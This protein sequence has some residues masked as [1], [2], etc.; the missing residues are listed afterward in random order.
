LFGALETDAWKDSGTCDGSILTNENC[1]REARVNYVLQLMPL[2]RRKKLAGLRESLRSEVAFA[3]KL[4]AGINY[5][6]NLVRTFQ[7]LNDNALPGALINSNFFNSGSDAGK[8]E[9]L[10]VESARSI[11]LQVFR[12]NGGRVMTSDSILIDVEPEECNQSCMFVYFKELLYSPG[13]PEGNQ[14][15]NL[16][17]DLKMIPYMADY[18]LSIKTEDEKRQFEANINGFLKDVISLDM[19]DEELDDVE[20]EKVREFLENAINYLH[21]KPSVNSLL[22]AKNIEKFIKDVLND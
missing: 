19:N 22:L 8:K 15:S 18:Y 21:G 2:E 13:H 4:H 11:I 5:D 14:V 7:F 12:V 9:K 1:G 20:K 16:I 17:F 10:F 3:S 6:S